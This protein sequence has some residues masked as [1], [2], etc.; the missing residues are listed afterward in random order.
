MTTKL[1]I[2][3]ETGCKVDH[4]EFVDDSQFYLGSI[5]ADGQYSSFGELKPS[6]KKFIQAIQ[7]WAQERANEQDLNGF[8]QELRKVLIAESIKTGNVQAQL[9]LQSDEFVFD[10][11]DFHSALIKCRQEVAN[12]FKQMYGRNGGFVL[13]H[14]TWELMLAM[15]SRLKKESTPVHTVW[16]YSASALN[17]NDI[18]AILEWLFRRV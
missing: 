11:D 4:R 6:G 5:G 16:E 9:C 14:I 3:D 15:I 1:D 18:E 2:Y 12:D 17:K 13:F 7:K 10:A 8:F